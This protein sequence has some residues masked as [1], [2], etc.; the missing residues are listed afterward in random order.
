MVVGNW[1]QTSND[2]WVNLDKAYRIT[3]EKDRGWRVSFQRPEIKDVFL[4]E[5]ITPK[6]I[7]RLL[8]TRPAKGD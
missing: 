7:E 5:E 6:S 8:K 4:P 3:Q 2:G 1:V